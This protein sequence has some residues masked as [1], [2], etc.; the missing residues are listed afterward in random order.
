MILNPL[1]W[2]KGLF[3][4]V[5][6]ANT[7]DS[8]LLAEAVVAAVVFWQETPPLSFFWYSPPSERIT[9]AIESIWASEND[10]DVS[11]ALLSIKLCFTLASVLPPS[12]DFSFFASLTFLLCSASRI[13]TS[14]VFFCFS[15]FSVEVTCSWGTGSPGSLSANLCLETWFAVTCSSPRQVPVKYLSSTCNS[16]LSDKSFTP[17][18][19]CNQCGQQSSPFLTSLTKLLTHSLL[20]SPQPFQVLISNFSNSLTSLESLVKM[21]GF[22]L[23]LGYTFLRLNDSCNSLLARTEYFFIPSSSLCPWAHNEPSWIQVLFSLRSD[24]CGPSSSS[25]SSSSDQLLL[26]WFAI[27]PTSKPSL[28]FHSSLSCQ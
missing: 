1:V 27:Q 4:V 8:L 28:R 21:Y 10:E 25:S 20:R 24:Q 5:A 6:L 26:P 16:L 17:F 15:L 7:Q 14:R 9:L 22:D 18:H 13:N 12:F 3:V 19:I 11:L 2:P 23:S